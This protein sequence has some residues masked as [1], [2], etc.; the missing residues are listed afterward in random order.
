MQTM[1][2]CECASVCVCVR[3]SALGRLEKWPAPWTETK[4]FISLHTPLSVSSSLS[5]ISITHTFLLFCP[6]CVCTVIHPSPSFFSPAHHLCPRLTISP[7]IYLFY[8]FPIRSKDTCFVLY[9][10]YEN[11]FFSC[12]YLLIINA[13]VKLSGKRTALGP[14]QADMSYVRYVR[15]KVYFSILGHFGSVPREDRYHG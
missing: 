7:V 10:L 12:L 13:L 3:S 9:L 1:C 15:S 2:M 8:R 11:L 14:M 6:V 4:L 5:A